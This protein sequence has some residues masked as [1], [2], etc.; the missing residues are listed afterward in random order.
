MIMLR[1]KYR[2]KIIRQFN[3]NRRILRILVK[4]KLTTTPPKKLSEKNSFH[5][6]NVLTL[7]SRSRDQNLEI[8][9]GLAKP[10]MM[11]DLYEF[12]YFLAGANQHSPLLTFFGNLSRR[13]SILT[14]IRVD[15]RAANRKEY[16]M[17]EKPET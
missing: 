14:F 16:Q 15:L 11:F 8:R 7:K 4:C 9:I 1:P 3:R 2:R 6:F 10:T 12:A 5:Y 13:S 17:A